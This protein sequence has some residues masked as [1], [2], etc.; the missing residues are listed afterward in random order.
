MYT[1]CW[2][3]PPEVDRRPLP[4]F[5]STRASQGAGRSACCKKFWAALAVADRPLCS[6]QPSRRRDC[7]CCVPVMRKVLA[8]Q[9]TRAPPTFQNT[10]PDDTEPEDAALDVHSSVA[11]SVVCGPLVKLRRPGTMAS[12]D[13]RIPY[14]LPGSTGKSK[15]PCGYGAIRFP[16]LTTPPAKWC[17]VGV[18]SSIPEIARCARSLLAIHE[19]SQR[20]RHCCGAPPRRHFCT[21]TP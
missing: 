14:F 8:K 13:P 2:F 11:D 16:G 20:T 7:C 9:A 19:A 4:L 10:E 18:D 5:P 17:S 21:K 15:R 1:S 3:P 12:D 6:T